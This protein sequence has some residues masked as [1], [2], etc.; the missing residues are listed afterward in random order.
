MHEGTEYKLNAVKS[1]IQQVVNH[2]MGNR[3]RVTRIEAAQVW[4]NP[5]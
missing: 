2:N 3:D 4:T 1:Q 5:T